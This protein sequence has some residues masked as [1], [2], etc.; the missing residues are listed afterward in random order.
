M[1]DKC[2]IKIDKISIRIKHKMKKLWISLTEKKGKELKFTFD[3]HMR[4]ARNELFEKFQNEKFNLAYQSEK[5]L[6]ILREKNESV[7]E[8]LRKSLE[9]EHLQNLIELEQWY[10]S[11]N[12]QIPVNVNDKAKEEDEVDE[13]LLQSALQI[14]QIDHELQ[15]KKR[16]L[17]VYKKRLNYILQGYIDFIENN[18]NGNIK[19][20][21][22]QLNKAKMSLKKLSISEI[23][24]FNIHEDFSCVY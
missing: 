12:K 19:L 8:Q 22:I 7:L 3:Y 2:K 20:K 13:S 14:Q 15:D 17:L 6:K 18:L 1:M 23:G 16:E 21:K 11:K 5:K 24:K 4:L 10:E 9:M